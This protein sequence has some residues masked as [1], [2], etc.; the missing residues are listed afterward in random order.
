M[1]SPPVRVL[2][3]PDDRRTD[4]ESGRS[5]RAVWVGGYVV[6][7]LVAALVVGGLAARRASNDDVSATVAAQPTASAASL[8]TA[9]VT[10]LTPT[11]TPTP[12]R[13]PDDQALRGPSSGGSNP[14][15]TSSAKKPKKA[16]AAEN[17]EDAEENAAS[18]PTAVRARAVTAGGSVVSTSV[19]EGAS[20]RLLNAATSKCITTD[21]ESVLQYPCGNRSGQLWSLERTR[22]V[23]GIP[24]YR[25]R[26]TSMAN[27]CV[28]VPGD[29]AP[30]TVLT[31]TSCPTIT[32][33]VASND[34]WKLQDVGIRYQGLTEYALINA[35]SNL[36]FD[37]EFGTDDG[38]D[39]L[40]GRSYSLYTCQED[41]GNWD[42]HLWVFSP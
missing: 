34:E 17:E 32:A 29:A 8:P 35:K 42:D 16:V 36:C 5:A 1:D 10:P 24:L 33:S 4:P 39:Q 31:M 15:S 2:P 30:K 20:Y 28:H 25:V 12:T 19:V 40:D 27:T 41:D 37:I 7:L 13:T 9:S 38:S 22:T 23:K 21:A 11:P 6:V 18:T 3:P 26:S 14:E